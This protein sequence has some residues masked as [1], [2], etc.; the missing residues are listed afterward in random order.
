MSAGI[1][2]VG[3]EL[4]SGRTQ[5]TNFPFL[6]QQLHLLGITVD[7]HLTVADCRS[8]LTKA[9]STLC[10]T[11]Q[12]VLITGGLGPTSDDITR[13]ALA[14]ILSS[15]LQLHGDGLQRIKAH[16]SR[17]DR[18]MAQVNRIQAMIP[19]SA[20]IIDNSCGTAP[21]IS[22]K[23]EGTHI[24]ALPGVPHEMRTMFADHV[25]PAIK[26]L[27]L[28]ERAMA[29]TR[30]HCC[31]TGESNIFALIEDLM[32]RSGN[33]LVGLTVQDGIITI[34]I[35]A[36]A[37]SPSA[38]RLLVDQKTRLIE[39][40]IGAFLFGRDDQTL[41]QVVSELLTLKKQTLALAESCTAGLIA[42]LLTDVPGSSK[43][44]L[45][46]LVTYCNQAKIRLLGVS[47]KILTRHGAVST[48]CARAMAEGAMN[49]T[50][51]DW[52][53]AV[54]GIAGPDGG[55][56]EKPV[57]LVYIA[58]A[59]KALDNGGDIIDVKEFKFSGDRPHIRSRVAVVALDT[60]RRALL[61]QPD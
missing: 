49:R 43:F 55:T 28:A 31:G 53:L 5:D 26:Q 38:A 32:D 56:E 25:E 9:L 42:K 36:H 37:D 15:P 51:A 46:D 6:A 27:G 39:S 3:D 4:L 10:G 34:S 61:Q 11:C 2:S 20:H 12:L 54:T 52:T 58:L 45:A 57:G 50:D 48:Q 33:P 19:A 29:S 22:A 44:F 1:I 8:R 7:M 21:G 40:R 13:F 47:E 14:D 23:L 18:P 41:P 16:F 17:L 59:G 35:N 24:F 30:L 60:L